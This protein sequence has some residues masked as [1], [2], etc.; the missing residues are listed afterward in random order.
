M[1]H[2][3]QD[4]IHPKEMLAPGVIGLITMI[5]SNALGNAFELPHSWTALVISALFGLLVGIPELVPLYTQGFVLCTEFADH[6]FNG[7]R[8][9]RDRRARRNQRTGGCLDSP[10]QD[11]CD[12]RA[13]P[14]HCQE[15]PR[16]IGTGQAGGI[17]PL[18]PQVVVILEHG[19][20]QSIPRSLWVRRTQ[21]RGLTNK[22]RSCKRSAATI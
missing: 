21:P 12:D 11:H 8:S 5:V 9:K 10:V 20:A 16:R 19:E 7:D 13:D 1:P 3:I 4:F 22:V 2:A 18:L 15:A 6:F 14:G 17:L